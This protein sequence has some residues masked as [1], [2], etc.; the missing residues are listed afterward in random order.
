TFTDRRYE[1]W[2]MTS[3]WHNLPEIRGHGQGIGAEHR[4]QAVSP[5][6]RLP[7][8]ARGRTG[9]RAATVTD[10]GIVEAADADV[11]ADVATVTASA[12]ELDLAPAYPEAAGVRSYRRRAAL[13]LPGRE[14]VLA[15]APADQPAAAP[16]PGPAVVLNHVIAGEILDHRPGLLRVRA[17]SQAL[18]E[19][20][21]DR[22][23]GAGT[24][25]RRAVDDPLLA[26]S[27]GEAVHRLRLTALDRGTGLAHG[28]TTLTVQQIR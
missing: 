13:E 5:Q 18:V 10:A 9:A 1:I 4:A 19:I 23:L 20:R 11:D 24:L 15:P 8:D 2:T 28:S 21:W 3:S 6:L 7:A 16:Q 22:D 14:P 12:L 17:L 26:Q 27:W 25:E